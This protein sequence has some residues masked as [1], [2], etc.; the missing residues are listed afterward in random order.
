MVVMCSSALFPLLYAPTTVEADEVVWLRYLWLP[1]YGATV[2]LLAWRWREALRGALA[3]APAAVLLTFAA[4]S[5][6]WSIAPDVTVRRVEALAFN[7]LMALY[8]ASRFSWR[9]LLR[10]VS[11][12]FLVLAAGSWVMCLAFPALGVHHL[13]N[14]GDWRGLWTEKNELGFLMVTGTMACLACA[15]I[16]ARLRGLWLAGAVTCMGLVI[17]SRSGTSLIC[18]LGGGGCAIG[19]Q[20]SKGRPVAGVTIAFLAGCVVVAVAVLLLADLPLFFTLLG[21]DPTLTGRTGVWT[22]VLR[23]IAERP[24]LGYGFGAFWHDRFGPAMLIRR[25]T[26]WDVPAAHNGWLE[27]GLQIGEVGVALV[28]FYFAITLGALLKRLFVRGD[29]FWAVMY[30]GAF[31]VLS[32]SESVILRQN[33]LEW[34]LFVATATKLAMEVRA[35]R[36]LPAPARARLALVTPPA[37]PRR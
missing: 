32:F 34:I 25:E 17:M 3:F 36:R 19:L 33:S 5:A 35:P 7:D 30:I 6:A 10:V 13:V 18:L 8:L 29:G 23:R 12:A 1:V 9:D 21:K 11:T 22:A 37:A 4:A 2:L 27:I 31:L 28:A 24:H 15:F 14:A 20:A 26:Q 16:D